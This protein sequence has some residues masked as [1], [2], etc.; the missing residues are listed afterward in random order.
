MALLAGCALALAPAPAVASTTDGLTAMDVVPPG[1]SGLTTSAQF[2]AATAGT[3]SSYGPHTDDQEP[4][5]ANWQYKPMQFEGEGMG[6]APPGDANVTIWRDA[7]G[8]PTITG[9]TDGDLFYGVGY[10]MAQDRLFQMEVF[11]HVGHGTLAQLIG[12]AGIPMDEAVRQTTE[13]P[14]A[15]Q[16]EFNALSPADQQRAEMFVNGINAYI[17][18]VQNNPLQMPAEFSLLGDVPIKPWAV[19]DALAFGEYAGR[20]FGEFDGGEVANAVLFDQLIKRYGRRKGEVIFNDLEPLNDPHAPT[21]INPRDGR[22]PIPLGHNVRT[23]YH[24]TR[25]A[26]QAPGALPPLA[27]LRPIAAQLTRQVTL[28]HRLQ[29]VLALPRWGSNAVI[30]SGRLTR[31]HKP[32]LYGGPQ[33]GWAV[34]GFFWEVELHSPSYDERGVMVPAIPLMVIGRNQDSAWTATSTE[35]GDSDTYVVT[36]DKSERSYVY[37]HRRLQVRKQTE[38]IPCNNP[39]SNASSL[40]SGQPPQLCPAQP[41]TFTVY[42]T[43]LGPAIAGPDAGRHLYV[44]HSVVDGHLL[45]SLTAWDQAGRQHSARA[46]AAAVAHMSLGFNFFYVDDRGEIGYWHTGLYPLRPANADQ[47]LP[48]PGDGR[49]D[50]QG[51]VPWSKHPHVINPSTGWLV[52]WNNKPAVGWWSKPLGPDG[53]GGEWGDSWE[54]VPLMQAVPRRLPMTLQALGQVPRDVAYVDDSARVF[55]PTLLAA[56]RHTRDPRLVQMRAYLRSWDGLRSHVNLQ[57]SPPTYS[58]PAI[59]FFDRFMEMLMRDTMEPVVGA[60]WY[61]LAGLQCST[62]HLVSVDNEFTPTY[63][64]EPPGYQVLDAAL[65]HQTRYRWI[66]SRAALFLRAARDAAAE[67]SAQQGS[68]PAKWNEPAEQT[69]FSAQG[70]ISVPP[71]TPL[72]NRGSYGQVIEASAAP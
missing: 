72:Q 11:R 66:R 38:T 40:A 9:K 7:W 32:M 1:E 61:L 56:L 12:A 55:L 65:H 30:V 41:V 6:S 67:L 25:Y 47:R 15:L 18:Q 5:Y 64:F 62:C 28:I 16:A 35:A 31:D 59:V 49:Y 44:R 4:L 57:T 60:D 50:W 26:N 2:A 69:T 46:F 36:L 19:G 42:R 68:D 8:V 22:F 51:F 21:S 13:G 20:F 43:V 34:P 17:A 63:K 23:R 24:A 48:Y 27:E 37:H 71:I 10:A 54:V 52:N 14:A 39:P 29:R 3:S 58:T 45:S 33:T 70:A 53:A